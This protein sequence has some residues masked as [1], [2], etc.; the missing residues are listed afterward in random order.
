MGG[1]VCKGR[2]KKNVCRGVSQWQHVPNASRKVLKK[3]APTKPHKKNTQ[4]ARSQSGAAGPFFLLQPL[5]RDR[6]LTLHV[7]WSVVRRGECCLFYRLGK[8]RVGMAH[9]RNIFGRSA[10]FHSRHRF[11]NQIG[12]ACANHVYA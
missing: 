8:R 6:F 3:Y 1:G 9:A 12:A 5:Y 10:V 7:Y 4:P 2:L 11:C